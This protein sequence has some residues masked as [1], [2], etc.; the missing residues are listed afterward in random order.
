MP[1][2]MKLE[3]LHFKPKGSLLDIV[4]VIRKLI[5]VFLGIILSGSPYSVYDADSPHADPKIWDLGV[6]ILGIC[7]GLQVRFKTSNPHSLNSHNPSRKWHGTLKA[8]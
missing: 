5:E 3:E 6:P 7:Y 8:K 4:I 2:T 1:C